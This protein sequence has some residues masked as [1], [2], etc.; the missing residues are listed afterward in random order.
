MFSLSKDY[1]TRLTLIQRLQNNHE[2]ECCW[3]DFVETYKNYIYVIIRNFNLK[4]ELNEDLLQ[5]VLLKLWKD[6]PK[7]EYRP[8]K[9]RFRTWLSLVTCNIVKDYLKSKAGNNAKKEV[10]YEE[11][12]E[13]MSRVSEPEIEKI[14]EK[15]WK[16][17][18]AEKAY[19]GIKDDLSDKVRSVFELSMQDIPDEEIEQRIG[20]ASSSVRVYKQRARNALIKE[21]T[22]LNKELDCH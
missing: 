1:S 13:S 16:V 11:A 15:E 9:C 18:I 17:F 12:L 14:A 22:R 8:N 21:I 20:I 7:F 5:N 10:Q 4:T 19:E 2:D 3:E 6:L